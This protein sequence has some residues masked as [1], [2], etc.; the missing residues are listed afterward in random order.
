LTA[1]ATRLSD[2][3]P[4]EP[5]EKQVGGGAKVICS[6]KNGPQEPGAAEDLLQIAPVGAYFRF[7]DDGHAE[8]VCALHHFFY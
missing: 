1:G 7:G 3:D 6:F 4:N 8:L 2:I 5:G